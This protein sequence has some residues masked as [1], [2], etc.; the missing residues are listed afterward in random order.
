MVSSLNS[1]NPK[2]LTL[3]FLNLI[4]TQQT[5]NIRV[6]LLHGPDWRRGT[7]GVRMDGVRFHGR[8]AADR[9]AEY[10]R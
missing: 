6:W 10:R 2:S 3:S 4:L 9:S 5:Q 8:G 7:D 1:L